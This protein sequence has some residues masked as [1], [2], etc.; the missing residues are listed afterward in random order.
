MRSGCGWYHSSNSQS[1]HARTHAT[2]S[3]WSSTPENTLPQ[4]PVICD[5]KFTDA[6][7]PLM[8]MSRTR[9]VDVVTARS[10]LV[11]AERLHLHGLR[12]P[13]RDRVHAD[14]RVA[15]SFEL[16][17]LMA[18]AGLDDPRRAVLERGGQPP[19]EHV[20][21]LDDVVVD[22]DHRVLHLPWRGL[23]EEQV[24]RRRLGVHAHRDTGV[25]SMLSRSS[26]R[27]K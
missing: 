13:A 24:G 17:D 5:G 12:A 27:M 18:R 11:E 1:F 19:L 20:R 21:W 2:P 16:P 14:L 26:A 23:R 15:L 9:G 25:N 10:H 6:H 3:S 7:T 4:N 8:S 22:R